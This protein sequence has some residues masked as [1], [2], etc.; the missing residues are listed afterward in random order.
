MCAVVCVCVFLCERWGVSEGEIVSPR[1]GIREREVVREI[2]NYRG[3][4]SQRE[5]E[6]RVEQVWVET[7]SF[8]K[9]AEKSP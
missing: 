4:G 2:Y 1:E 7:N 9:P 8:R 5:M 3:K 6:V